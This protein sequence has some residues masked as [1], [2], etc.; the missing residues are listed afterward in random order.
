ML[1]LP[2]LPPP[3]PWVPPPL[4]LANAAD[5]TPAPAGLE[6]EESLDR[7]ARKEVI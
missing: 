1:L 4:P 3:L 6:V 2:L 5:P 7:W